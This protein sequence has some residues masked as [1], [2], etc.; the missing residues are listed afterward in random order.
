MNQIAA[1][2]NPTHY[3]FRLGEGYRLLGEPKMPTVRIATADVCSPGE[4]E[5]NTLHSIRPP[6]GAEPLTMRWIGSGRWEPI[7]LGTGR[8]MAYTAEYLAACGWTYVGA[9]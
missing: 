5:V 1:Q 3:R 8:R 4:V 6:N 2:A 9:A 7:P